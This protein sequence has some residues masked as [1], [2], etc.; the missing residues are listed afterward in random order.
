MIV[1]SKKGIANP[2]DPREEDS[3]S[4]GKRDASRLTESRSVKLSHGL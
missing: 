4:T 3:Q 2:V 1:E